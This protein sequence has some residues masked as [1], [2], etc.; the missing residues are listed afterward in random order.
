VKLTLSVAV[1][2]LLA[3]MPAPAHRLDEYLQGTLISV[4]KNRIDA[5]ITLTPGV[6]VFPI[7]LAE[8]DTDGNGVISAAEQQAYADRVLGD[9]S[10]RI[11]DQPLAPQLLSME[12]P[13]LDEMKAGRGQIRIEFSANL[14]RGGPNRKLI[15]ENHHQSGIAAYQVNCLVPRDPDIRILAQ[16]RNYS[17]SFYELDFVQATAQFGLGTVALLLAAGLTLLWRRLAGYRWGGLSRLR[18]RPRILT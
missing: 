15:F 13:A 16:N 6:A 17:Q 1:I 12:F 2:V 11:D 10:L 4:E 9:L 14:P 3:G 5:Q 7:L 18:T 8:I